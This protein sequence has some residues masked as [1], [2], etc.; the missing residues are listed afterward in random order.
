MFKRCCFLITLPCFTWT[1]SSNCHRRVSTKDIDH[2]AFCLLPRPLLSES[3]ASMEESVGILHPEPLQ[4][5][6]AA[7]SCHVRVTSTSDSSWLFGM[8]RIYRDCP[9][10]SSLLR[11]RRVLLTARPNHTSRV[12]CC[13]WLQGTEP[14]QTPPTPPPLSLSLKEAVLQ[15]S[16]VPPSRT[17]TWEGYR[18]GKLAT[19]K[20]PLV[21]ITG[22]GS[23]Y[24]ER[25]HTPLVI[26]MHP[27]LI[28]ITFLIV[29]LHPSARLVLLF[30][31]LLFHFCFIFFACSVLNRSFSVGF[32]HFYYFMY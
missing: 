9:L 2:G 17:S 27:N 28:C 10:Q 31:N 16:L 1:S 15:S 7:S 24:T 20:L 21:L 4:S 29:V 8:S 13:C 32:V 6:A 23:V 22:H 30:L 14:K 25:S 12:Q 3:R 18:G 19:T 5:P 26:I 11:L